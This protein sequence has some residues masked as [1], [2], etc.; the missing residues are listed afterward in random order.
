MDSKIQELNDKLALL[1]W[2]EVKTR[3]QHHKKKLTAKENV[4]YLMDDGS[5]KKLE[6][7]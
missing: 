5:L 4:N 6:C 3:K 2:V 1:I 7:W